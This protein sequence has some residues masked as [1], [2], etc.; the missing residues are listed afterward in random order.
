MKLI[1]PWQFAVFRI[2]FGL[3]LVQH[4]AYLIAW[5]PEI[6]GADGLF[7]DATLNLTHG[8]L[9]NP[10]EWWGSDTFV[11]GFLVALLLLSIAFTAVFVYLFSAIGNFGILSRQRAQV[12]PFVLVLVAVG[13]AADRVIDLRRAPR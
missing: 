2:A 4:F 5:G 6:W 8:V 12:L 1:S 11:T 10:L 13:V 9:P 7:A 3:Y